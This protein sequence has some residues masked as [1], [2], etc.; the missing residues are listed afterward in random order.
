MKITTTSRHYDLTP[1]LKEHAEAKIRHL[2]TYFDNIVNAHII[3]SMEKYR[4]A[5]EATLHANGKDFTG[6]AESEDMYASVD[7]VAEKLER[8]IRKHKGKRSKKKSPKLGELEVEL[9][10]VSEPEENQAQEDEIVPIDPIE[11]PRM[12]LSEALAKLKENGNGFTIFSNPTTSRINVLFKRKDGT[13]G[14]IEAEK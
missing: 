5:F 13:I 4:H 7:K 14:L 9:P 1:A 2:T 11:F 6:R 12:S 3:F 10:T 8:Q